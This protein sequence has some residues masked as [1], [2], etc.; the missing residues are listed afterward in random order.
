MLMVKIER[1][2][3]AVDEEVNTMLCTCKEIIEYLESVG[4]KETRVYQ[5]FNEIISRYVQ[6]YASIHKIT[7]DDIPYVHD[8][9]MK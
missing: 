1:E 2:P 3:V 5:L 7:L 9:A 8:E 6:I 4:F